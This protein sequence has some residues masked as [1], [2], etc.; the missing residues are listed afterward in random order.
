MPLGSIQVTWMGEPILGIYDAYQP[1]SAAICAEHLAETQWVNKKHASHEFVAAVLGCWYKNKNVNIKQNLIP[2]SLSGRD[3]HWRL[4]LYYFYILEA[5]VQ[6]QSWDLF[7][8]LSQMEKRCSSTGWSGSLW[9]KEQKATFLHALKHC[10][11]LFTCFSKTKESNKHV[12]DE[13]HARVRCFCSLEN[14]TL[15]D[16]F[17]NLSFT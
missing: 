2:V 8:S 5:L 13:R 17:W 6:R 12:S 11:S 4:F 16:L 15:K 3:N 10:F 1:F 7:F 14:G 9:V